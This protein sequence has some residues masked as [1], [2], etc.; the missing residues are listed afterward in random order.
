MTEK[1]QEDKVKKNYA[2]LQKK[3]S[4]PSLEDV[5]IN[6]GHIEFDS[7]DYLLSS[8]R[9]KMTDKIEG[10]AGAIANVF[11]GE[12]NLSSIYES[13]V[14]DDEKKADLFRIYKRLMKYSRQSNIL[15]LSYDEKQEA[16]F[17]KSFFK[18]W[19]EL[20]KDI[21]RYLVLFMDSWEKD[22]DINEEIQ[23]YLG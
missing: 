9:R 15:S 21:K 5:E 6:F 10:F 22:T 8:I 16:E 13:K 23:N 17:V 14:L 2:A 19:Q 3:Y 12:T 4:L 18:E 11:E 7:E 20:K 1:A